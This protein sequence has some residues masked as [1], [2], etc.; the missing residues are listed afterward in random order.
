MV[1]IGV[2]LPILFAREIREEFLSNSI[3]VLDY[4]IVKWALYIL[5]ACYTLAMGV[6][7]AGQFIYVSF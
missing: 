1:A 7:D 3:K 6:L 5:V 4:K 2:G